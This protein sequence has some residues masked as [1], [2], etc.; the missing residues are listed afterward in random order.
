MQSRIPPL[1]L[2]LKLEQ[3]AFERLDALR[4]A[5]F[6][7]ERNVIPAH[8]TL[9]HRLPGE[10]EAAIRETVGS[11]CA[12]T[13]VL[14]MRFPSLR[15]LGRGGAVEVESPE[16]IALRR[17]LAFVW[18]GWL[19]AQDRQGYRPHITVQ[20]KVMPEQARELCAALTVGWQ[21]F[22]AAGE[23]LLLWRYLGGPWELVDEQRF[24]GAGAQEPYVS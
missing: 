12:A 10:Q 4:R 20:N 18:S 24:L 23:G 1:I 6:P 15:F 8:L 5:H 7:P 3:P 22:E 17:Q 11:L 14:P 13:P 19:S 2:T 21:P 16:L 9:F